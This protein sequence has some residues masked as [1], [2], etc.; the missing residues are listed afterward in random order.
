MPRLIT[1]SVILVLILALA[2]GGIWFADRVRDEFVDLIDRAKES[3]ALEDTET[4]L[5]VAEEME[6]LWERRQMVLSFYSRH[7]ELEKMATHITTLRGCA[8]TQAFDNARITL[9]QIDFLA[10]HIHYREIPNLNNLL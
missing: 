8:I 10:E 9:E 2:L 5:R 3:C 7:D 4:L 6:T 1:I